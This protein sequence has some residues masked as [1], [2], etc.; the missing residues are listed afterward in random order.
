VSQENVFNG[1]EDWTIKAREARRITATEM[2]YKRK[3]AEYAWTGYKTNT[4]I[5]QE[6]HITAILDKIQEYRINWLQHINRM[7]RNILEKILKK[8]G[9]KAKKPGATIESRL[10]L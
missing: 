7:L 1:S 4:E 5:A 2:K 10:D 3:A 8:L 9:K 6:L